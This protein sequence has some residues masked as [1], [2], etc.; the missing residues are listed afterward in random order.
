MPGF[1][2]VPLMP[3]CL[4]ESGIAAAIDG[5]GPDQSALSHLEELPPDRI[6]M[7]RALVIQTGHQGGRANLFL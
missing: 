6:K 4:C 7:D 5:F 3:G 1:D 2:A